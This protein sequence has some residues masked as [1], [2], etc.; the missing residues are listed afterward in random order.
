M[1]EET[2]EKLT[3]IE[4]ELFQTKN[5]AGQDPLNFPPMLDNQIAALYGYILSTY[6]RPNA[7]ATE[8]ATDL[9]RELAARIAALEAII[10]SDVAEFNRQ[11]RD[12]GVPGV[13]IRTTPR[14]TS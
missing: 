2:G 9:G 8:R 1:A 10:Q 12:K 5:E 6:D 11:L 3:A 13:V 7:G 4:E 14:A